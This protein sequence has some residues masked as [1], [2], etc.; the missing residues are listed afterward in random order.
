MFAYF[1]W[2]TTNDHRKLHL[3]SWEKMCMP[4][5]LGGLNFRDLEGFNQALVEKQAWKILQNLN[6]LVSKILKAKYFNASSVLEAEIS[7]QSSYFLKSLVWGRD[8]EGG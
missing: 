1:W 7:S 3:M 2:D 4:K 8:Q 6:F 5:E